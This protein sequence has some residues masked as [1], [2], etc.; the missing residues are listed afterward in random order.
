MR[1]KKG[2]PMNANLPRQLGNTS[3]QVTPF[4][5]GGTT[6]GNIY[7]AVEEQ[8]AL[9]TIDA[10]YQAG[11][12]YFDTAPLYGYGLS[13][14]RLGK[15]LARYPRDQVVISTKVGWSLVPIEPG[16]TQAIDIFAK[17]LPFRGVIDYSRDAIQR[18]L[19][20]SLKRLNVDH[21][22]IVL[23]H[24]P[25][26]ALS[27]QPGR[28]P[29]EV[30]HFNAAMK[31]AYPLLDDLRRQGVIKAIGVG[32]N[33]WQM[34]GDFA[35]AGDFD[36]FLL[37]GRYTLLEQEPLSKFLPLCAQKHIS[38]I[39]G[40]P[41]NSGILATGA[42]EG[43]YYNY[44]VAP[45]QV[46]RRVRQIEEVCAR[47]GVA[48]QAAAL[49]FP[50]GHPTVTTIIPGARSV[51]ELHANAGYFAQKIPADFWA[52]LKHLGLIDSTAPVPLG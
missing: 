40:G 50:F 2:N 31:N 7:S 18:S 8:A 33:Q 20:E 22:D 24:D 34:L 32:M 15:G 16:Q 38:V 52:E 45:P 12:R 27:I 42:V 9:D 4:G 3:L 26:E 19:A 10:A 48:L 21:I 46:L 23:M 30:S 25:D 11:V 41:Y 36:C 43:A 1:E 35:R 47:H 17:A 49:Q 44:R 39:I 51:A 13:E 29:Y 37:A 5:L 28:D 14:L 6:L